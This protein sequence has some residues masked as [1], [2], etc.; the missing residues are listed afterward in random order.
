MKD[1]TSLFSCY[2]VPFRDFLFSKGIRYEYK[3]ECLETAG[4]I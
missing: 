2:S 1:K 3:L 4:C